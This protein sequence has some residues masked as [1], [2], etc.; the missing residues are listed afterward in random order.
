MEK[1]DKILKLA[2]APLREVIF[3]VRWELDIAPNLN[4]PIDIN[5]DTA[6][7]MMFSNVREEFPIKKSKFP[8]EIIPPHIL[9]PYQTIYQY[10]AAENKWPVIQL[11]PG[12]FTVNEIGKNY[13]W[14]ENY[15]PLIKKGINW[16]NK[17]YNNQELKFNFVSLRYIDN[18][19]TNNYKFKDL[20]S[21]INENLNF[22]FN[23]NFDTLGKLKQLRFNQNF[24]LDDGSEMQF[25]IS[26]TK[27]ILIWE[28][29]ISK[30]AF[31]N[32]EDL[33][34]WLIQNHE[35][36]SDLFI[37]ICKKELYDSFK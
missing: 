9:L 24:E 19:K 36:T 31:F 11:G 8:A 16:L 35:I 23:Y 28:T 27:D 5:F 3:E 21:F 26:N 22:E 4:Q 1:A 25:V 10:W 2:N 7:G 20:V 6:I 12:I 37:K 13:I 15:F 33:I 34:K 30:S 29:A 18:I 32:I 17:S 14:D